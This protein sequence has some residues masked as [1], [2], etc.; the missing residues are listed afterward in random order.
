LSNTSDGK[1]LSPAKYAIVNVNVTGVGFDGDSTSCQ[2]FLIKK[3]GMGLSPLPII[4]IV[5]IPS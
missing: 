3:W 1:A 5:N 4:A 2:Q